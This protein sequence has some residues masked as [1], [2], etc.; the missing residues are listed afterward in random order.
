MLKHIVNLFLVVFCLVGSVAFGQP[1]ADSAIQTVAVEETTEIQPVIRK[2]YIGYFEA[3]EK[4][5]SVPRI[6]GNLESVKFN[7]GDMIEKGQLLFEIE[8]VRYKA[9]VDE[10]KAQVKEI[11]SRIRY[12]ESN[13]NRNKTLYEKK[14][15]SQDDAENSLSIL[16]G[17]RA[18]LDSAQAKLV[19]AEDDLSHTKIYSMIKG[20]AGRL[21]YTPGN[22]ITPNSGALITIV[23]YDPIYISFSMS[24][25]DFETLYGNVAQLKATASLTVRLAN[26]DYY[27]KDGEIVFIDNKVNQKTDS[28]KIWAKFDNPDEKLNPGGIATVYLDKKMPEMK[29][30]VRVSAIMFDGNAHFVYVMDRSNNKIERRDVVLSTINGDFQA[31]ESGLKVGETVVVDGT[32]K[33]Q[34]GATVKPV[35]RKESGTE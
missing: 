24:E 12:A 22:Y 11:E 4:V 34:P 1:G 15:G 26:G 17:Y 23:Q 21:T 19:L 14:A 7:E 5:T 25:H 13:Y 27:D 29:T 10:A 18:A 32:H 3:I 8:D 35:N 30:A 6:S 16:D 20:R 9:A 28:I 31:I 33:V 2:K